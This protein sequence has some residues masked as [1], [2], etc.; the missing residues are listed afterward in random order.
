MSTSSNLIPQKMTPLRG[1]VPMAHVAD[2]ERSISF[3]RQIGF[4]AASTWEHDGHVQWAWVQNGQ[5]HLMLVRS[6]R[7]MD[8]SAQDVLFY[9][10]AADVVACRDELAARGVN[11]G[12][13]KYPEYMRP[14][15]FRVDDPEGYCLLV[16]QRDKDLIDETPSALQMMT[17]CNS[18]STPWRKSK[19]SIDKY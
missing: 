1:L 8:A 11:V 14:G 5:A 6:A 15:E 19:R 9:L 18:C 12:A 17:Y 4:A 13:L 2:V 3:Y 10:Y 16:G 7:P